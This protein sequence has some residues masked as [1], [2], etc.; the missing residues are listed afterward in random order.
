MASDNSQTQIIACPTCVTLNRAP[1]SK[2]GAGGKCGRCGCE[3]FAATAIELTTENFNAYALRPDIPLLVDFWAHWC[4]PCRQMAPAFAAAAP[5]L[6]PWLRL[7]K[8]DTQAD[9][10]VAARYAIR[11]IPTMLI[12]KKGKE[13]A[14]QSGVMP[15]QAIVLWARQALRS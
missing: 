7:G 10:A 1:L 9:Q 3:L 8:L 4:S 14:R 15:I 6:E 2:L 11:T 5:Q 13:I 12:L